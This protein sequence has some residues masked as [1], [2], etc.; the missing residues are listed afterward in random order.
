MSQKAK[1][2]V[3][4]YNPEWAEQFYDLKKVLTNHLGND[5]IGVEHVGSTAIPG[6]K[7]KSVIDLDIIIDKD[8]ASLAGVILKLKELGYTHKGNLGITGREAFKRKDST[9]PNVGSDKQWMAHHLYVCT[10]G[11]IGLLNH[12]KLRDHLLAHPDKVIEY[13][14]LKQDLSDRFPYDIDAYID[15]KTDFIVGILVIMGME[16]KDTEVISGENKLGT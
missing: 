5:I 13:S 10:K 11:S 12:L 14:N 4:D 6:M 15:G 1:I 9:T 3:L 7:A 16:G 2:I 8:G